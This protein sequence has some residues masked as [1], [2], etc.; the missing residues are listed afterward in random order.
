MRTKIIPGAIYR[1]I[2]LFWTIYKKKI[3]FAQNKN[4]ILSWLLP[5]VETARVDSSLFSFKNRRFPA[6]HR[7][8]TDVLALPYNYRDHTFKKLHSFKCKFLE[9]VSIEAFEY[10]QCMWHSWSF[11]QNC[12]NRKNSCWFRWFQLTTRVLKFFLNSSIIVWIYCMIWK[13]NQGFR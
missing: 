10:V 3:L 12:V 1:F 6:K 7:K 13:N 11:K 2:F 9:N 8:Y 4:F 5:F